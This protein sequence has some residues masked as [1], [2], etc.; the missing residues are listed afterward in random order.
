[1]PILEYIVG[2]LRWVKNL[3]LRDITE[4]NTIS[5]LAGALAA[6]LISAAIGPIMTGWVAHTA[7][8]YNLRP[9]QSPSPEVVL[10][11][12]GGEYTVQGE[13]LD[14]MGGVIYNDSIEVYQ[15]QVKN[16][17]NRSIK[18]VDVHI[19]LPGCEVS[20]RLGGFGTD[21]QLVDYVSLN[22]RGQSEGVDRYSCS[23]TLVIDEL[24]P[25]DTSSATFALRTSFQ[26][27]DLLE[28]V[29]EKD[30]IEVNYQWQ[31][32]GIRFH[33]TEWLDMEREEEFQDAFGGIDRIGVKGKW[34]DTKKNTYYSAIV[35]NATSIP[36]GMGQCRLMRG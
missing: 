29:G 25:G 26:K 4:V 11:G 6:I 12:G 31:K 27:C 2:K 9:Y 7:N 8:D 10:I 36:D 15:L 23:K 22:L 5:I 18:N 20:S 34:V 32:N 21:P 1:M 16:P 14:D 3:L 13:D 17:G 28:G 30:Q 19:P 35:K 33:E 24:D